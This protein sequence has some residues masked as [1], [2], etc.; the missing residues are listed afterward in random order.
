MRNKRVRVK[1]RSSE[2]GLPSREFDFRI[3]PQAVIYRELGKR[4][5]D[6]TLAWMRIVGTAMVHKDPEEI[7]ESISVR[8]LEILLDAHDRY[9]PKRRFTIA[10][11]RRGM[12]VR[13]SD[14]S[15]TAYRVIPWR[16]LISLGLQGRW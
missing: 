15:A 3:N 6:K 16:T 13:K 14:E 8:A 7:P 12:G 2:P 4:D 11:M 10:L 9:L 1:I 5:S